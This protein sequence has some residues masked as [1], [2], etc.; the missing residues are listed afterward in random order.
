MKTRSKKKN[1][2]SPWI[3]RIAVAAACLLAGAL[4][5][6]T[7][8]L[9]GP[10]T[11]AFGD[12]KYFY[13]RTGSTY[14]DVLEGLKE[15]RIISSAATFDLVARRLDYPNR[16]K[17]GRYDIKAGMSNLDIVRIL[18]SGR[19]APVK[20]VINKLRTKTDFIRLVSQ[21]LE[22]DSL[23]MEAILADAVY[24]RQFGLNPNTVM[25]AVVPNTYEFYWNTTA[26]KVFEKLEKA[27]DEFWSAERKA[28]AA[29]LGFTPLEVITLASIVEEETNR[30]DEKPVIASVYINRLAK[31]MRLGAD[32]TV[33]FAL[34]DFSLRRI[35]NTHTQFDSPYNTY[36]YSGLP[37][38]PICTPSAKTIDAVLTPAVTSYLFF[39]AKM[40]GSGSHAFA[41][42]YSEHMANARA[43]QEA[44]NARGIR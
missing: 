21:N 33:K 38:G 19:Q 7:Y 13:V 26:G 18:R 39:C 3:R 6:G 29:A 17:A 41:T 28:K 12:H 22:A 34:Q 27:Y 16:V 1:N 24:L 5:I 15:Q 43:Y 42:T 11:R 14:Q 9:L 2:R 8:L 40:D 35:Y 4:V 20:L 32:P 31:G 44:L 23:A 30:N 37:P 10:N 25:A 36:R